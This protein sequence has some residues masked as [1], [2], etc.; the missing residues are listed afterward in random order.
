MPSPPSTTTQISKVE[1]PPWVDKAAQSN[2]KMAEGIAARPYAAY[3]G[4]TVAPQDLR[5]Q[6]YFNSTMNTGAGD[7]SAASI[8]D[9]QAGAGINGLDR[10]AYMNPFTNDVIDNSLTDMDRSRVMAL[11]DNA[12]KAVASKAFGGSRSAIID[13]VT[14]SETA[15]N[16]GDLSA[17]LRAE[18]F[19]QATG[20]MQGDIQS[21]IA[22]AE[23]LRGGADLAG[24]LR[25]QN[26]G[27]LTDIGQKN[28]MQQQKMF[29]DLRAKWQSKRDAPLDNLNLK[30]SALG[31]S[32]Y[33]K[34][35]STTKTEKTGTDF[36][37]VGSGI[38]SLLPALFMLSD[39][40]MK[41]DIKKVGK[42]KG[43]G[44]PLYSY[45]YKGDPKTYPKVVG[46]MA[47]DVKKSFP[48]AVKR[49]GGKLAIDASAG[50]STFGHP[51]EGMKNQNQPKDPIDH[52][53]DDLI[54]RLRA[55]RKQMRA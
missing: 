22:A 27:G 3:G 31:M 23:G 12:S 25:M 55:G 6:K 42:D 10:S 8:L 47:Q 16:A 1:L 44:L 33:G 39:E 18:D 4:K 46:P 35:E 14:N 9:K 20:A 19:S 34:T 13:A 7:V 53:P 32:P 24:K 29:D 21:K 45:R 15:R 2:Y 28:Q 26:F 30:L 41:T 5:A 54:L 50:T 51:D 11:N 36:A 17:R 43:T 37:Q 40:T 38:L 49:I 48:S 52:L